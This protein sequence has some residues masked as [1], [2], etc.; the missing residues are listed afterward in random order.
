[1]WPYDIFCEGDAFEKQENKNKRLKIIQNIN[2][3]SD[4]FFKVWRI[5]FHSMTVC[6]HATFKTRLTVYMQNSRQLHGPY[7]FRMSPFLFC[8]IRMCKRWSLRILGFSKVS[9]R[10]KLEKKF[11]IFVKFVWYKSGKVLNISYL[12]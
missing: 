7:N 12:N 11:S 4:S 8:N 2:S 5:Y 10:A 1:M 3:H 6:L 9:L